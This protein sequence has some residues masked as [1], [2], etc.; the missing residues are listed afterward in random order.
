MPLFGWFPTFLS[1]MLGKIFFKVRN[2]WD[3]YEYHLNR[4]LS[5]FYI[6]AFFIDKTLLAYFIILI[7]LHL[8]YLCFAPSK[9]CPPFAAAVLKRLFNL[10]IYCA[11]L[12]LFHFPLFCIEFDKGWIPFSWK[13]RFKTWKAPDG[14]S[15]LSHLT[16]LDHAVK[17]EK[18][19]HILLCAILIFFP[20]MLHSWNEEGDISLCLSW[21]N[22]Y[23]RWDVYL[24]E[25]E[26]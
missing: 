26:G 23:R 6:L 13:E 16:N 1:A 14:G 3:V 18:F 25:Q 5:F 4:G 17:C 7:L 15:G 10:P 24:R 22:A 8:Q 11:E 2:S 9:H 21:E 19:V 20:F 12:L